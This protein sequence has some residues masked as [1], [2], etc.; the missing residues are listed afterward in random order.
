MEHS[1]NI[2]KDLFSVLRPHCTSRK[3][4]CREDCKERGQ[5]F[6]SWLNELS[7][8]LLEKGS[9]WREMRNE[10]PVHLVPCL[11]R[12]LRECLLTHSWSKVLQILDCLAYIPKGVDWIVWKASLATMYTEPDTNNELIEQ[13]FRQLYLLTEVDML[14]T[15]LEYIKFLIT[16]GMIDEAGDVIKY[17][18]SKDKER[19]RRIQTDLT[20]NQKNLL[21]AYHGLLYYIEWHGAVNKA[22]NHNFSQLSRSCYDMMQHQEES[23]SVTAH[24]ARNYA[25]A[26]FETLSK[27][28]GVWDIFLSKA[29]EIYEYYQDFEGAKCLLE[30]YRKNNPNN[31]NSH[32]FLFELL[33]RN[34]F[35]FEDDVIEEK[36]SCLQS[37]ANL[38]PANPLVLQ[39][40]DELQE[41]KDVRVVDYLFDLLDYEV[42]REKLE[43]WKLLAQSLLICSMED[44]KK[45]K[46]VKSHLSRCWSTRKDWWPSYHF[47]FKTTSSAAQSDLL[48]S[49]ILIASVLLGEDSEFCQKTK[50]QLDKATHLDVEM[51]LI[52][53]TNSDFV[54]RKNI[55]DRDSSSSG[56]DLNSPD[57]SPDS[58]PQKRLRLTSASSLQI[59]QDLM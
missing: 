52:Q 34:A 41:S 54:L 28:K 14:E 49:K 40:C 8:P 36:L 51:K 56:R 23:T 38:D 53:I 13:F 30:N 42:W 43:G 48:A 3:Q 10:S 15:V 45:Q 58:L 6:E 1:F 29:V 21:T 57:K 39:L 25:L 2:L 7:E 9:P 19:R 47:T 16:H 44:C 12:L 32:R 18:N 59:S 17:G 55:S 5:K 33:Q 27:K 11:V 26:S 37:I 4:E 46:A 20:T 22:D 35:C 50:H 24:L 31:P